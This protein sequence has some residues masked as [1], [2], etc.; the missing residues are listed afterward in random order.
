M[1]SKAPIVLLALIT[2]LTFSLPIFEAGFYFDDAGHSVLNAR[3][4][5]QGKTRAQFAVEAFD[6]MW[7]Q[8][9][10]P[11]L[12][13]SFA[14]LPLQTMI[15]ENRTVYRLLHFAAWGVALA[16][17]LALFRELAGKIGGLLP[18]V[19]FLALIQLRNWHD[20]IVSYFLYVPILLTTG[21]WSIILWRRGE[22]RASRLH[23]WVWAPAMYAAGLVSCNEFMLAFFPVVCALSL[24]QPSRFR[25]KLMGLIPFSSLTLLFLALSFWLKAHVSVTYWGVTRGPLEAIPSAYFKQLVATLPFSCAYFNPMEFMTDWIRDVS[26]TEGCISLVG[27]A[28]AAILTYMAL[29]DKLVPAISHR[30]QLVLAGAALLLIPPALTAVSLKYQ[31]ELRWGWGYLQMPLQVAG[32]V[33]LVLSMLFWGMSR[34]S[35]RPQFHKLLLFCFSGMIGVLFFGHSMFNQQMI[36]RQNAQATTPRNLCG[37]L[38]A[39]YQ[40]GAPPA[41]TPL[42]LIDAPYLNLWQTYEFFFAHT[43]RA[44]TVSRWADY[45]A[46]PLPRDGTADTAEIYYLACPAALTENDGAVIVF[47]RLSPDKA[48]PA[49]VGRWTLNNVMIATRSTVGIQFQASAPAGGISTFSRIHAERTLGGTSCSLYYSCEPLLLGGISTVLPTGN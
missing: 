8:Q 46:T 19:V 16:S 28:S 38:L 35:C 39:H 5:I 6:Y 9:G 12:T 48:G 33:F 25:S 40:F 37:T 49:P 32:L 18:L 15:G 7:S 36:A 45:L 24:V 43:R 11:A 21:A 3:R 1:K 31:A 41:V 10:R 4:E 47:G 34:I 42:L 27:G 29:D 2:I 22:E 17:L 30:V 20:G 44:F 14:T 26:L 13:W 23:T